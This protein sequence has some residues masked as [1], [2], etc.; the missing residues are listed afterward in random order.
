MKK[1]MVLL[2]ATLIAIGQLNSQQQNNL[3]FPDIKENKFEEVT[4]KYNEYFEAVKEMKSNEENP[5][6]GQGFKPFKRWEYFWSTRVDQNGQLPTRKE[7]RNS[8]NEF[9]NNYLYSKENKVQGPND[10]KPLG[11]YSWTGTGL[12]RVNAIA[13]NPSNTNE[14]YLGAATGGIWKSTNAG[15]SWTESVTPD[16]YSLGITDIDICKTKPNVILAATGDANGAGS[17]SGYGAF[18]SGLLLSTNNG[19]TWKEINID[20]ISSNIEQSDRIL[21][22]SVLINH[23]NSSKFVIATNTGVY[24]SDNSGSSWTRSNNSLCRDL[25]MHPTNPDILYGAFRTANN[26]YTVMRYVSGTWF[27]NG[28]YVISNCNRVELAVID[29]HPGV[30]YGLS[31][32]VYG[33]F[34]NVFKSENSGQSWNEVTSSSGR[35]NYLY[36]TYDGLVN[37]QVPQGGQGWY[38]LAIA[39]SPKSKSIV[40]IGGINNWKTT[41]GGNT[42][43]IKTFQQAWQGADEVHSDQHIL[44]YDSKGTLY[45]GN[46]GGIYK[47][48][49]DGEDWTNISEGLNITQYYKFGQATDNKERLIAGAQDNGTILKYNSSQWA[50]VLGGDGFDCDID[51]NNSSIMYGSNFNQRSGVF[52]KSTSGGQSWGQQPIIYPFNPS[53]NENASWVSPLTIDPNNSN[54]FVGYQNIYKSTNQGSNWSKISNFGLPAYLT[55]TEIAIAPSNSNYIYAVISNQVFR[56]TNGGQQWNSV[57][58]SSNQMQVRNVTVNPT[59]PNEFYV[60]IGGYNSGNKVF[61]VVGTSSTNISGDLPNFPVNCIVYQKESNDRIYI[62]TDIGVFT[63]DANTEWKYMEEGMPQV[64]I[65]E[66]KIHYPSGMLRAAT[67]GRGMWE[68]PVNDCDLTPP[69][70]TSNKEINNNQINVCS[71]EDLELTLESG[72]YDSFEWSN[73]EKSKKIKPKSSGQYYVTIFD[74]SGCEVKSLVLN[75]RFIDVKQIRITDSNLNDITNTTFC[76]G[77]SVELK[78]SG[79]Y[80]NSEWSNGKKNTRTIWVSKEGTYTVIAKTTDGCETVS[81]SVSV[82]KLPSPPKPNISMDNEGFLTTT[83]QADKYK[84]YQNDNLLFGEEESRFKPKEDGDYYVETIING[85][86]CTGKSET[87]TFTSTDIRIVENDGIF[88]ISPNPFDDILMIDNYKSLDVNNIKVIDLHGKTV[89]IYSGLDFRNKFE[90]NLNDLSVGSYILRIETNNIVVTQKIIK[91]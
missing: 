29:A 68:I 81:Q 25:K 49:N 9:K 48:T 54:I 2:I 8:Y 56:T 59:N 30:C 79:L 90:L 31:T 63:K 7:L 17:G 15:N 53:I 22:Y 24:H 58:T 39:V 91:N 36:F 4:K 75:V 52:Y 1:Y 77:D 3:Q 87:Y 32:D 23:N 50:A 45:V 34:R 76:D 42:Y 84:W 82:T 41:D 70:I 61:K 78:Y 18:S 47:S 20:A 57:F 69:I 10:W 73:G 14:I 28:A 80:T 13:V 71:G 27:T 38:D 44:V 86:E 72:K 43:S 60:A 12:G 85:M 33:G 55:I 6:K 37:G 64:I 67:Y 21:I 46:D 35:P 5:L 16:V 26:E 40:T 88:K 89:K 62:G 51:P 74:K 65:S 11:P 19:D 66:L 83:T